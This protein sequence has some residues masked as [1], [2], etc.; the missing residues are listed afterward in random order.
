MVAAEEVEVMAVA[1]VEEEDMAAAVEEEDTAVAVEEEDTEVDPVA[2][3]K[4]AV[5]SPSLELA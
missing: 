5:E 1:V 4:V 2:E 3:E